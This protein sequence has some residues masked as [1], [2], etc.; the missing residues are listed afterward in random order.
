MLNIDI[1]ILFSNLSLFP[2]EVVDRIYFPSG[3]STRFPS[4]KKRG[5]GRFAKL[6][7]EKN[8]PHSP[9]FSKGDASPLLLIH[10]SEP[11]PFF[12]RAPSG[13]LYCRIHILRWVRPEE[14]R[15]AFDRHT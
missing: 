2:S 4:L 15:H 12:Y 7:A 13:H 6:L 14:Y 11:F 1:V 3:R 9:F 5:Q 10:K 8:P